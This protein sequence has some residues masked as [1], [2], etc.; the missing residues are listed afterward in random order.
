VTGWTSRLLLLPLTSFVVLVSCGACLARVAGPEPASG[1]GSPWSVTPNLYRPCLAVQRDLWEAESDI[2]AGLQEE[3]PGCRIGPVDGREQAMEM[4]ELGQSSLAIVS[5]ERPERG[6]RLLRTEDFVLAAHVTSPWA[7]ITIDQ[8]RDLFSEG[9]LRLPVVVGDGLVVRELLG[10]ESLAPTTLRVSSWI[11]AKELVAANRGLVAF[12]P[13]GLV[14]F[15]TRALRVEGQPTLSDD[16]DVSVFERHWW[17]TGERAEWPT[18][19]ADLHE[20][21][22]PGNERVVSLLA[23]GDVMLGR[24]IAGLMLGRGIAGLMQA[25]STLYPFLR[26]MEFTRKADITFGNLECAI[27]SEGTSQGGIALRTVPE[28]ASA[29][30]EAGFDILS[31]ANNHADDYGAEGLLDTARYLQSENI[32][33]VGLSSA[34]AAGDEPV[35][36]ERE[37]L[38]IAFLAFNHVGPP[39]PLGTSAGPNWLE[40]DLVY[41]QVRRA[42]EDADSVVVSLHWGTEYIPLPDDFQQRVAR[43][44]LD[45][46]ADLVLGHHPHVVGAVSYEPQG[47]VAYSLGNYVFDQPFSLETLQGMTVRALLSSEGLKQ[48]RFLPIQIVAGQPVLLPRAESNAVLSGVFEAS[49][50]VAGMPA[51]DGHGSNVVTETGDLGLDLV[52]SLSDPVAGLRLHDLHGDGEPEIVV[53]VGR[54]GGPSC[55]SALDEDGSLQWDYRT[56]EQ[57]NDL[58]CGDL[59]GD[60]RAEVVVATGTLDLPG[61]VLAL[62]AEGR[63]RWRFGVEASVLDVALGSVDGDSRSEVA[64]GEWGAFGDTVYLL[65]GEGELLWKRPT[66]GSVHSVAIGALFEGADHA[67]LAGAEELYGFDG[68]G[69]LLLN[70]R[71]AGYVEEVVPASS[72]D[73]DPGSVLA[74]VG[75]PDA[76]IYSIGHDGG[77]TWRNP[78]DASPNV[79][80]PL[81]VEGSGQSVVVGMVDGSLSLLGGDGSLHWKEQLGAPISDLAFGDVNGDDAEEIVV[82]TGDYLTP[83]GVWVVDRSSGSLQASYQGSSGPTLVEVGAL[84]ELG[85][86]GGCRIVA[87]LGTELYCFHWAGH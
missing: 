35:V 18:M 56:E 36:L 37:E 7:E 27:T 17:L 84:G 9:E 12:L 28:A 1:A 74:A 33:C 75:Y 20:R 54:P 22:A 11:E 53:A 42:A 2:F 78:L 30:A 31:L 40:P 14:D 62:D 21:L 23:V 26:T 87:G 55:V 65:D 50:A 85:N 49:E 39:A 6:G 76:A 25:N 47:L 66:R 73:T 41:E 46:G 52:T 57:I 79:L 44:I 63:L 64:A 59:D 67:V 83:G 38:R 77:L 43:S 80:L 71:T 8:A 58:E 16:T 45:A 86:G 4:L 81:N 82:G 29:L 24:G 69:G 10:V 68:A 19:C 15:T 51:R 3:Y 32:A 5:G 61:Q 72:R 48:V 70:Y 13:W 34:E 60:G